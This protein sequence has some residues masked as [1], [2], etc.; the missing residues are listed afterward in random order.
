MLLL[1]LQ[2]G[3]RHEDGEVAVLKADLFYGV[4][5]PLADAL[6]DAERPGPEDVASGHVVVL[7]HLRLGDHLR[8][9]SHGC[10]HFSHYTH[11]WTQI[12]P[13]TNTVKRENLAEINFH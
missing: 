3:L 12:Y 8:K 10:H 4:V 13:S 5:K 2:R 1:F 11:S 6:P 9:H 7:D